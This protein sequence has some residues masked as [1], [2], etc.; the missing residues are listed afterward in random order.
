[1]SVRCGKHRTVRIDTPL[2]V[3]FFL[4][5]P[6]FHRYFL[7]T[8][9]A[10]VMSSRVYFW[11]RFTHMLSSTDARAAGILPTGALSDLNFVSSNRAVLRSH[12]CPLHNDRSVGGHCSKRPPQSQLRRPTTD[13]GQT[14]VP[15]ENE[16]VLQ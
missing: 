8:L 4:H 3:L 7:L 2:Q 6:Q 5:F 15:A 1:M 14:V 11:K 16:L 10:S 9:T 13:L 12:D